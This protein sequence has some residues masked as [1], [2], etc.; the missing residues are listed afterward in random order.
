MHRK[1]VL[2]IALAL[3][4][5][6]ASAQPSVFTPKTPRHELR[7]SPTEYSIVH[8]A[9]SSGVTRYGGDAEFSVRLAQETSTQAPDPVNAPLVWTLT[10][11]QPR[12]IEVLQLWMAE[13][14]T[15]L[16]GVIDVD[17]LNAE[18]KVAVRAVQSVNL[19]LA[20]AKANPAWDL[21]T[22]PALVGT[23]GLANPAP[24]TTAPDTVA[25]PIVYTLSSGNEI[26][27]VASPSQTVVASLRSL[28]GKRAI[29]KGY[30][31]SPGAIDLVSAA[32]VL[33]N[34]LELVVMSQC[35][36]GVKAADA[37]IEYLKSPGN[38]TAGAATPP[39]LS[40]RYLFYKRHEQG[41][42]GKPQIIWWSLHGEGEV[43]ENLVQIVIRDT[44]AD[45]FRDYVQ[46]RAHS[47][48]AAWQ[49]LASQVGFA[50]NEIAMIAG[51]IKDNRA[52]IIESEHVY[53]STTLGVN[54]GSPTFAWES[55]IVTS[56]NKVPVFK[57]IDLSK[58][59]CTGTAEIR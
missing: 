41:S 10:I 42:D 11:T 7:L 23:K 29:I 57:A 45:R 49:D 4:A 40:I 18:T 24:P 33:E 32:P 9:I 19:K 56:V 59:S 47:P 20:Q 46:R 5:S 26:V 21:V 1:I 14:T 30:V 38:L 43:E 12:L 31:K 28:V 25:S 54:D 34:T 2:C 6:V 16:V 48:T 52:K 37:V 35:P 50:A 58:G 8:S 39:S 15:E 17:Q 44:F 53:V 55:Q 51:H 22:T 3:V 13:K 36:F 27:E